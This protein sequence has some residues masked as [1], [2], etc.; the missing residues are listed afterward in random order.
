[1]LLFMTE[2]KDRGKK[3]D[4][5]QVPGP[6]NEIR[7]IT[8]EEILAEYRRYVGDPEAQMPEEMKKQLRDLG[9]KVD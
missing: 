1:M 3:T 2:Q 8:F 5:S 7:P 9:K 6:T 4:Y